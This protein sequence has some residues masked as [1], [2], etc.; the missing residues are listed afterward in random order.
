MKKTDRE[1]KETIEHLEATY[2]VRRNVGKRD[3][4]YVNNPEIFPNESKPDRRNKNC[5]DHAIKDLEL[6]HF[7]MVQMKPKYRNKILTSD[8]FNAVIQ[9]VLGVGVS[10]FH[11]LTQQEKEQQLAIAIQLFNYTIKA[12]LN[13]LPK[14]FAK[15]LM[16]QVEPLNDLMESIYSYMKKSNDKDI[17]DFRRLDFIIT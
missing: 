16:N 7:F 10:Q 3:L 2:L 13:N 8:Q 12:L 14:E 1:Q 5:V 9:D 15:P 11:D 4:A 6:L 17:P